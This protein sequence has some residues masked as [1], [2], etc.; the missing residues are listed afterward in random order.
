MVTA[1]FFFDLQHVRR[2]WGWL[3]ALGIILVLLGIV[4]LMLIPVATIAAVLIL[5]WLM[6][7]S[8]VV[9]AVHAF[10]V[11]GWG[12]FFLHLIG[13][14]LGVLVGL[15]IVTHPLAGALAWTLLF[16]AVFT[17]LGAFRLIAAARLKFPN[18]G[19]AAF[20]GAV[21]LVLG[22]PT[23][24]RLAVFGILVPRPVGWDFADIA[25]LVLRD[26][27]RRRSRSD[28]AA[29]GGTG[30]LKTSR[31]EPWLR[32]AAP[33]CKRG[34][35]NQTPHEFA[36]CLPLRA[37]A[38]VPPGFGYFVCVF[39]VVLVSSDFTGVSGVIPFLNPRIP[40]PSALPNSGS[41]LGPKIKT[42]RINMTSK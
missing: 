15:L 4:A 30:C 3:L 22:V 25:R 18:W 19:W 36:V 23:V 9:E 39:S 11:R 14:V 20:D 31:A 2:K 33:P 24:G 28:G 38:D 12:G 17:V 6:V 16:A 8:G 41:F 34:V 29:R 7:I 27:R 37:G 10:R 32:T 1:P 21:T 40:S 42:H 35:V 5:G 26:V 13:G